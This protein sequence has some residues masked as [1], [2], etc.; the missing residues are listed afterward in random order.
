MSCQ[1]LLHRAAGSLRIVILAPVLTRDRALFVGIGLDQA[2]IDC[3]AFTSNETGRD[4]CPNDAFEQTAKNIAFS[5]I[6]EDGLSGKERPSPVFWQ[7]KLVAT[8]A[9]AW[10][11]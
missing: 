4:A 10:C 9:A 6:G 8:I 1:I 2:R 7:V 5:D 3:K 11:W